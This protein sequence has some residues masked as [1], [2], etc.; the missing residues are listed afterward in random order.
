MPPSKEQEDLYR[1]AMDE[2]KT[3]LE[4][5][6]TKMEEEI[7]KTRERLAKLQESKK[8]YRQI[9]EGI[10]KL[11][12]EDIQLSE[13]EEDDEN[14]KKKDKQTQDSSPPSMNPNN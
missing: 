12:G 4:S 13:T 2:A 5:I 14:S 1:K 10:A 7:Q 9:Y 11:L 3:E 8:Y 6:D